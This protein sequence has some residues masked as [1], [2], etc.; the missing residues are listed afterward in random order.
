VSHIEQTRSR[1]Q[2]SHTLT[3]TSSPVAP[4]AAQLA[5]EIELPKSRTST[6]WQASSPEPVSGLPAA[7]WPASPDSFASSDGAEPVLEYATSYMMSEYDYNDAPDAR[8]ATLYR[9][10]ERR[11]GEA[12]GSAITRRV[13]P[14][15]ESWRDGTFGEVPPGLLDEPGMSYYGSGCL[16]LDAI[17]MDQD[18]ED[19][20]LVDSLEWD[21]ETRAKQMRNAEHFPVVGGLAPPPWQ[22][23]RAIR[24]S[25]KLDSKDSALTART[26]A[27]LHASPPVALAKLSPPE[28]EKPS[29]V[30]EKSDSAAATSPMAP[31]PLAL[32]PSLASEPES[33]ST[34]QETAMPSPPTQAMQPMALSL[35]SWPQNVKDHLTSSSTGE[36][37]ME[38]ISKLRSERQEERRRLERGR[39]SIETRSPTES[40]SRTSTP[41]TPSGAT[42]AASPEDRKATAEATAQDLVERLHRVNDTIRAA[43]SAMAEIALMRKHP[44]GTPP[45]LEQARSAR[46]PVHLERSAVLRAVKAEE[47]LR[48]LPLD[49]S[50]PWCRCRHAV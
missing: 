43:C 4:P 20:T 13:G 38:R 17:A 19:A 25:T 48:E 9:A 34:S 11:L 24:P 14:A 35:P 32:P 30:P 26:G 6:S 1:P 7:Y 18:D 31:S 2:R 21:R 29:P 39:R 40:L 45:Y 3:G 33:I 10:E 44:D 23:K 46:L 49:V 36:S 42:R 8:P 41:A 50:L 12:F 37:L 28:D 16:I 5:P 15:V 22:R 47:R 27:L